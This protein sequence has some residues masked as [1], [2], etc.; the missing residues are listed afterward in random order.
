MKQK[1][2]Q[3]VVHLICKIAFFLFNPIQN[4]TQFSIFH[5]VSGKLT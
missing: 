2:K 5:S 3:N 4:F 1:N